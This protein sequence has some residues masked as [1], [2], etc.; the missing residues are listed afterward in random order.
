M[1]NGCWYVEGDPL[2]GGTVCGAPR[3]EIELGGRRVLSK[4]CAVHRPLCTIPWTKP[5]G[6]RVVQR[7]SRYEAWS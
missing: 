2:D 4:W 7:Q 1:T 3:V 5:T 6:R